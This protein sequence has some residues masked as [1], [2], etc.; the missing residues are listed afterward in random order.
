MKIK[1]N[2][3]HRHITK[4]CSTD[5]FRPAF[6][7]IYIDTENAVMVATDSFILVEIPVKVEKTDDEIHKNCIIPRRAFNELFRNTKSDYEGIIELG[8]TAKIVR[9]DLGY[10]I[11][12]KLI[13]ET[14][15][16]YKKLLTEAIENIEKCKTEKSDISMIEFGLNSNY[17]SVIAR[18]LGC[19][20]IVLKVSK[21]KDKPI[22]VLPAHGEDGIG[23][24]MTIRNYTIK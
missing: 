10:T 19:E 6:E 23:M 3:K 22:I 2:N 8:D 7:G 21:H 4:V 5:E 9:D 14:F 13:N 15:P 17:P 12:F 20:S 11:D 18:A 16:P 24:L 1:I